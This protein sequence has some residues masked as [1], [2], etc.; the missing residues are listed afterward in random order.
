[1]P[2]ENLLPCLVK[3]DHYPARMAG[4]WMFRLQ[5][6]GWKGAG[7]AGNASF[8]APEAAK[9]GRGS[10]GRGPGAQLRV[11]G[12]CGCWACGEPGGAWY[13][14][15]G[16]D[17]RPKGEEHRGVPG[18]PDGQ[19]PQ[20][21]QRRRTCSEHSRMHEKLPSWLVIVKLSYNSER[22]GTL[23]LDLSVLLE[24]HQQGA[25]LA[26]LSSGPPSCWADS[27]TSPPSPL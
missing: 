3:K 9:E 11:T 7:R 10:R 13:L 18:W 26:L 6:K 24:R 19:G 2:C 16:L 14:E 17:G 27:D 5:G 12:F 1:M 4:R 8:E 21:S 25:V 20:R 15:W 23:K 22:E